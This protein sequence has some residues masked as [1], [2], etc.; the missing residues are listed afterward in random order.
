MSKLDFQLN[1]MSGI[2]NMILATAVIFVIAA[3]RS[4]EVTALF[5]YG[6]YAVFGSMFF[7]GLNKTLTAR[8]NLS[9]IEQT[10]S[11]K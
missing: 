7:Y 8:H 2:I 9:I 4:P 1:R 5:V 6:G 11:E 3:M 10:G